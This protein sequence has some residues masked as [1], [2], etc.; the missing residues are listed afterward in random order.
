MKRVSL[1]ADNG[2][3]YA[4]NAT[5]RHYTK[6]RSFQPP[7]NQ[8]TGDQLQ[9][10]RRQS[11][12]VPCVISSGSVGLWFPLFFCVQQFDSKMHTEHNFTAIGLLFLTISLLASCAAA[13]HPIDADQME[14]MELLGLVGCNHAVTVTALPLPGFT[15]TPDPGPAGRSAAEP[16]DVT[17][18]SSESESNES[19]NHVKQ[20]AVMD[21]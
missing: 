1:G 19:D 5:T 18:Q 8:P 10:A 16:T 11:E 14:E 17:K 20:R 2:P 21:Q 9:S 15:V 4:S 7:P 6:R 12:T 13:P 3:R